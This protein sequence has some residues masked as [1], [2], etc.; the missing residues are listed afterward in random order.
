MDCDY[1]F[2]ASIRLRCRP[3]GLCPAS[4]WPSLS[5]SPC[6]WWPQWDD[7]ISCNNRLLRI[8][9][10]PTRLH[11]GCLC[12]TRNEPIVGARC[13]KLITKL[14]SANGMEPQEMGW[15]EIKWSGYP[16]D[17][18]CLFFDSREIVIISVLKNNSVAVD[19]GYTNRKWKR[20]LRLVLIHCDYY[21]Y[22][23]TI[24]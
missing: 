12:R 10:P 9:Q 4:R 16:R 6:S 14:I 7:L 2:Q 19:G 23:L 18:V 21:Y 5:R 22:M 15:S 1:L 8:F 11:R 3:A 13:K 20:C 24:M 17:I